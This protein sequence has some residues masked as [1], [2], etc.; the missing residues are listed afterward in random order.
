[1]TDQTLTRKDFTLPLVV[2][3]LIIAWVVTFHASMISLGDISHHD[4]SLNLDRS[5]SFLIRGDWW[6]VYT[7]NVVNFNKPPLQYWMSALL[8]DQGVDLT[9]ALRLPSF[10]FGGLCLFA[11]ALFAYSLFP[12]LPWVIPVSVLFAT[13]SDR[14][15]ESSLMA[16]LD[17]GSLFFLTLALA[18]VNLAFK[19]SR[20]WYLVG[21]SIALGALHKAPIALG[22][23]A[24]Y[25]LFFVLTAPLHRHSLSGVFLNR[26]FWISMS[27]GVLFGFSWHIWQYVQHGATAIQQG[28]GREMVGRIAPTVEADS[29]KS[30]R[31]VA[32]H[33]FGAEGAIRLFGLIAVFSV[34]LYF[35]RYDLLPLPL[36][37]LAYMSVFAFAGGHLSNR[38][39]MLFIVIVAV[40]LAGGI[41][42]SS[43]SFKAKAMAVMVMSLLS[44]GPVKPPDDLRL[45]ARPHI[46][47][48][49]EIFT[50]AGQSA[51]LDRALIVCNWHEKERI[52]PGQVTY[53]EA[54]GRNHMRINS[55]ET[56]DRIFRSGRISGPVEGVCRDD[57]L[58]DLELYLE[59]IDI[60]SRVAPYVHF[61]AQVKQGL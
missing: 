41:L 35:K 61:R 48:Q 52:I 19:D 12:R 46:I 21:F 33:M 9:V 26:H 53:Y 6:N 15:W 49:K 40:M 23:V 4:E 39:T 59:D 22:F 1:V 13:S 30:I 45:F 2:T 27:L 28:I 10:L 54:S 38:Y 5:T 16:M 36:I 20:W 29:T 34:P 56:L 55:Q 11:T 3:L 17:T 57:D 32:S 44:G 60:R 37:L 43:Y 47:A 50:V 51:D 25:L 42:L 7:N 18:G 8:I 24:A 58:A 14:F 31:E